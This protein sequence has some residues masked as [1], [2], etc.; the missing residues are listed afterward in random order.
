VTYYRVKDKKW[1]I[2]L[3]NDNEK[4]AEEYLHVYFFVG[5]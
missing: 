2:E 4:W 5:T 3:Y 1:V